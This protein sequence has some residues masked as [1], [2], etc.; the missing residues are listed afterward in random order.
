MPRKKKSEDIQLNNDLTNTESLEKEQDL[1]QYTDEENIKNR[2]RI[3]IFVQRNVERYNPTKEE[4]L[5]QE[6]VNAR[7]KQGLRNV[8]NVKTTKSVWDIIRTNVFTFFNM[9]YLVITI[10]LIVAHTKITNFT[11]V[12]IVLFNLVLGIVQEL[13][14]KKMIEKL[15]LI[16][17][18]KAN[19]IRDGQLV[20]I[21]NNEVVLD[22]IVS[23]KI[24][25]QI[26][27]DAI[28]IDGV[29]EVNEAM[30]TGEPN[31]ILKHPG[32]ILYSGSYLTSG[33]I[34]AKI[35]NVGKDNYIE[36][37]AIEAK[38][39]HGNDSEL[40]RTLKWI[41]KIIGILLVPLFVAEFIFSYGIDVPIWKEFDFERFQVTVNSVAGSIIGMI[42]AG[43][44]LLSTVSLSQGIY[45]LGK[46][47]N[48]SVQEMYSIEMLARI[49]TL[50]LDKTGTIT[51]GTMR[52]VDCIELKNPTNYSVRDIIGSMMNVFE[53]SN[54]TSDALIR[55][56]SKRDV[57][58]PT[59]IL[60]FSSKRKYS[61]ITFGKV[62]TFYLGAPEFVLF[63]NYD[64][65]KDK[66]S[67]FASQACRVIA[68]AYTPGVMKKDSLPKASRPIALIAIQD[69]IR[70]EAYDT[71]QFF[72][73]N[74]VDVKVISGDN[75]VTVSEIA[76]RVGISG[77]SR[78]ISLEGMSDEEV[79]E[80]ANDYTIYGR[81]TPNQ[82][83]AL[84]EGLK[85]KKHVVA[86][87]G[88]GVNDILAMKEAQCSIAM[89]SGSDAAKNAANI[90]LL[91]SNFAS[92]PQIVSEGRR[93]INN[94]QR[95]STLYL[96]KTLLILFLSIFYLL[97]APRTYP[98]TT[99]QMILIE[100]VI[101]GF[102]SIVISL[103]PNKEQV[104]GKFIANVLKASLPGS[105]AVLF[106]HL[107]MFGIGNITD[108]TKG[109]II[110][111]KIRELLW[112][113]ITPLEGEPY[114]VN[115]LKYNPNNT[116]YI[117]ITL[118]VTIGITLAV[119]YRTC[120]P[121]DSLRVFVFT[122]ASLATIVFIL[123]GLRQNEFVNKF[124]NLEE[125]DAQMLLFTATCLLIINPLLV[126]TDR[127][128]ALIS[129]IK[130]SE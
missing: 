88:D 117:T 21:E 89:A 8:N 63:D 64:K 45:K 30:I 128:L 16:Q 23:F 50:C 110:I 129:K 26:Y 84:V 39:H 92:L 6:Q 65:V 96:T 17:A 81:V 98:Y 38:K 74:G 80:I 114:L 75:P 70:D 35:E 69:H 95:T 124:L 116:T 109:S 87:T 97:V 57:L 7:L 12:L 90:V 49:D 115:I 55:F 118:I 62:G 48:T 52:V 43:L 76:H 126:L 83:K 111:P 42:P 105:L 29:A 123:L 73:N 24:G 53:D 77:Y 91:D 36:K 106:F 59:E 44:F 107:I 104:Q 86:M 11:Y 103:Q 14:A 22:D 99:S 125:L 25:N 72:K 67:Q 47:Y 51:D 13:K 10:L 122:F 46:K 3:D 40:L 2:K 27:S 34:Y 100:M 78:Y 113:T 93:V 60:P 101:I 31:A 61:A 102:S 71:L 66:V 112:R 15:N 79:R 119:L 32:D 19:V 20:E 94:I 5:N 127:L 54:A 121:F 9:L 58:Q 85:D 18:S 130:V 1:D 4:G 56:F 37:L 68:L 82:K 28:V 41:I 33:A 120:K 108:E